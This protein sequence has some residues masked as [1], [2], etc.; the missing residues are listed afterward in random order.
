MLI[1]FIIR[2]FS[3]IIVSE[4]TSYSIF[5]MSHR[6]MIDFIIKQYDNFR[7][8]PSILHKFALVRFKFSFSAVFKVLISIVD[9]ISSISLA[10]LIKF[11]ANKFSLS[12][13][14]DQF[15]VFRSPNFNL[16]ERYS[17]S[18][19]KSNQSRLMYGDTYKIIS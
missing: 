16:S 4:F 5:L 10:F 8:T 12:I 9:C 18:C 6:S 2:Y 3:H 1:L 13:L 11:F 19:E 15:C 7:G 14:F 17:Y